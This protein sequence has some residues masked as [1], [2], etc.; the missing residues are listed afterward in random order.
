MLR[1]VAAFPPRLQR[2]YGVSA[3]LQQQGAPPVFGEF[4]T[5][6]RTASIGE[7]CRLARLVEIGEHCIVAQNVRLMR[8]VLVDNGTR[9]GARTTVYPNAVLGYPPQDRKYAGGPTTL[10]I[11]SD[12][13]IREGCKVERGT[14]AGGGETFCGDNV[15]LM[16]GVYIGHDCR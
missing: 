7:G 5:V 1:L 11:G 10:A 15:L 2:L 4:V 12:C 3:P 8:N 14:E 9:I 13:V 16:S 6:G